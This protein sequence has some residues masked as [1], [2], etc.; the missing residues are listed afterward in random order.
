MRRILILV[1]M[2]LALVSRVDAAVILVDDLQ[3]DP[4][5]GKQ[6]I[7]NYPVCQ[8]FNSGSV[9]RLTGISIILQANAPSSTARY[10]VDLYSVD[11]ASHLPTG[12]PLQ[13]GSGFISSLTMDN[14]S[15]AT[16]S[17]LSIA[18]TPNT[19][20]ALMVST[21]STE[22]STFSALRV[23][24]QNWNSQAA[25]PTGFYGVTTWQV[26][27]KPGPDGITLD[28]ATPNARPFRMQIVGEPAAVPE[29][30]QWI[31]LVIAG[32]ALTGLVGVRHLRSARRG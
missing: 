24:L 18:V 31:V 26:A 12:S 17:G 20:Y 11:A 21:D 29:P 7:E 23:G 27:Y 9:N 8:T 28:Y 10:W 2:G 4:V 19:E 13:I 16:W 5:S 32:L 15:A 3:I 30:E 6:I 25:P 14:T 1:S 22:Y